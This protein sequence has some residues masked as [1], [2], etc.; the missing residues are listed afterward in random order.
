MQSHLEHIPIST[1]LNLTDSTGRNR[2]GTRMQ[3]NVI[4]IR[5]ALNIQPRIH[6]LDLLQRLTEHAP[7]RLLDRNL[8]SEPFI[9]PIPT[10]R[11]VT[12]KILH[13]ASQ[14]NVNVVRHDR[15]AF[16]QVS[17]HSR[18]ERSRLTTQ[19]FI[20]FIGQTE[21]GTGI[22][23]VLLIIDNAYG[24][25]DRQ[26]SRIPHVQ[27]LARAGRANADTAS[28]QQFQLFLHALR[29]TPAMRQ[30]H[31]LTQLVDARNGDGLRLRVNIPRLMAF[32]RTN[33]LSHPSHQQSRILAEREPAFPII[34]ITRHASFKHVFQPSVRLADEIHIIGRLGWWKQCGGENGMPIPYFHTVRGL[35][36]H[37]TG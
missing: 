20:H 7:K 26:I 19:P 17:G 33:L 6:L 8:V 24:L 14:P 36:Y 25:N 32:R 5:G 16:Q 30:S 29:C 1:H 22:A 37:P 15:P 3:N 12:A 18:I 34:P 2:R 27:P 13:T 10:H 28:Q 35:L 21:R 4:L 31:L 11:K 23:H 9:Q